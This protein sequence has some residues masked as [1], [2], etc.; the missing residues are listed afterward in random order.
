MQIKI[1]RKRN[2]FVPG[3]SVKL[4]EHSLKNSRS[5]T[6]STFKEICPASILARSSKSFTS[7][8]ILK[9]SS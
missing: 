5:S 9:D 1:V 2:I 4:S 3:H 6:G 7:L 8:P